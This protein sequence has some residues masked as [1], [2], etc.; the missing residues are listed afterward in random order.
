[1]LFF[2][3]TWAGWNEYQKL[4]AYQSWAKQFQK[5]KYDIYAVLGQNESEITWGKPTRKGPID[6]Q[7]FSLK[8]VISIELISGD[9]SIPFDDLPTQSR[10]VF[11]EFRFGDATSTRIPFTELSLAAQW[12]NYLQQEL[13]RW[14]MGDQKFSYRDAA[15]TGIRDSSAETLREQ[16]SGQF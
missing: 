2:W 15:Q 1:M 14:Q 12:G 11:L 5:S 10:D 16:E 6:L 13:S 9:R 4:E 3:L 8:Q 7:T